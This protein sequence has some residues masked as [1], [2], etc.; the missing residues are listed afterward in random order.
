MVKQFNLAGEL[1]YEMEYQMT[2][3]R[4][5]I[6]ALNDGITVLTEERDEKQEE[7]DVL[8]KECASARR[9]GR[10]PWRWSPP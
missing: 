3:L 10:R 2:Q 1:T 6:K 7:C 4:N 5:E 8:Q 9:E